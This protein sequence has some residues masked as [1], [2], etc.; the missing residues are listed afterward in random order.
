MPTEKK[1]KKASKSRESISIRNDSYPV[2]RKLHDAACFPI[3]H[4]SQ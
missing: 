2:A 1:N 3:P 4:D